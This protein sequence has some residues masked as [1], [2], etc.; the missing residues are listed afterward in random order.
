MHY[1]PTVSLKDSRQTDVRP[2]HITHLLHRGDLQTPQTQ[3]DERCSYEELEYRNGPNDRIYAINSDKNGKAQ[4]LKFVGQVASSGG[5]VKTGDEKRG[6]TIRHLSEAKGGEEKNSRG[7]TFRQIKI[8]PQ[9]FSALMNF[10]W[11]IIVRSL[12]D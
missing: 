5:R 7:M 2:F 11:L 3:R 9:H 6:P 10:I 4:P 8:I 12:E 1:E